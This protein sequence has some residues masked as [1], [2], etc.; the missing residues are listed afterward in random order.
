VQTYTNAS[1]II[2][3]SEF[4]S[5]KVI[6][7]SH[8]DPYIRR[9]LLV[10]VAYGSDTDLVKSLLLKAAESVKEVY[11]YPRKPTVLFLDFGSSSLDFKLRFWSSIDDFVTAESQLRFEI[12]KLFREHD[13]VIP[14][15]QQ[16]VHIMDVPSGLFQKQ[17]CLD[18][19]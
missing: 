11:T 12:D 13:V 7:W 9:D 4:I 10:G 8:Q 16:D 5:A 1:L 2:P 3:N 18:V 15:P 14:F 17:G 6:N 19:K